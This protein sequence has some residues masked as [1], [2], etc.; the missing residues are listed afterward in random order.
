MEDLF[1]ARKGQCK[2]DYKDP[3]IIL[4][5]V[6]LKDLWVRHSFFGLS[7]F[8][9]NLDVLPTYHRSKSLLPE[10]LLICNYEVNGHQYTMG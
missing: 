10:I 2:G 3:A 9:N 7:S 6:A 1:Y 4:E 5:V 8:H